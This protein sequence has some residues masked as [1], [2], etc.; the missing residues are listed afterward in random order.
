MV[1]K[2]QIE[3]TTVY[4]LF[5]LFIQFSAIEIRWVFSHT[6]LLIICLQWIKKK[7]GVPVLIGEL[8]PFFHSQGLLS[9]QIRHVFQ[10]ACA[11]AR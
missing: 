1:T 8:E 6:K 11:Q 5:S 7:D 9:R 10:C 4:P 2:R 3:K